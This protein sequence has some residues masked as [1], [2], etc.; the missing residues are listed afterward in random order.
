MSHA[1]LAGVP[2]SSSIPKAPT[3]IAGLDE[4]TGGGL[5]RGRPTL[6][7]GDAG[8]GKTLFAIECVVRG[9]TEFGEPGVIMTFEEKPGEL[10]QNVRSLGFDLE[11]MIA[12]EQLVVD[13]VHLER[14][15]ID[16]TG[17]FDL[18]G[19]FVRLGHS[20]DQ[21]GAKRVALDTIEMLFAG[22]S[23]E[24][25]LRAELRRLFRFLKDKGVT[26][27]VTCERGNGRFSRHGLE[28]Y[29]SDCVILLDHRIEEQLSTRRLR[30]VKYR[31][32][33]HGSD[34]YP[35]IIG[36]HGFSV[37]P[38]TTMTLEH[39]VSSER[40]S[41][42]IPDLDR[43]FG[44][45]YYRGST[46]LISGTP[47][48]GKTSFV[49][50][51]VSACGKRGERCLYVAFEESRAQIVRNMRSIGL[52]LDRLIADG[53]LQVHASRP[54]LHGMETHLM[55]VHELVD[56]FKPTAVI[57]DPISNLI[58]G[59]TVLSARSL[60]LRLTDFLKM[61]QITTMYTSL[62]GE[63]HEDEHDTGISSMVD[64]WI[65]LRSVEAKGDRTRALLIL[66]SRGMSHE[67]RARAFALTSEGMRFTDRPA[68]GGNGRTRAPAR[69][70]AR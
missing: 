16:E 65:Q 32:S 49:S 40:V 35:F 39:A 61:R 43:M 1:V 3:G 25:I 31:G 6:V 38:I 66:K 41:T 8:S 53:L 33:L 26:A 54:T 17:E 10:A 19:L 15:E 68:A 29:I 36:T 67:S 34:E 12:D 20:I 9:A 27:I 23:N 47:G 51:F 14:S 63:L 57:V 50:H 52:D 37:L 69:R 7:C 22:L 21:I 55:Q 4:I 5:P 45:G 60:L 46:I 64:T 56:A 30:V 44:G 70:G 18:D 58:S 11:R 48:T 2:A 13:Y 28:E 59:G 24:A 42:G 62:I